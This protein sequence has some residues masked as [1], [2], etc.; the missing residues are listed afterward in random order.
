MEYCF[1][2][3]AGISVSCLFGLRIGKD[4]AG[5]VEIDLY[6]CNPDFHLALRY[7]TTI[8]EVILVDRYSANMVSE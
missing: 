2:G 4:R 5:N 7:L 8:S 1:K 6:N 3:A